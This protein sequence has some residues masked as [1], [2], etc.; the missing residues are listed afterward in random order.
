MV[1]R[2]KTGNWEISEVEPNELSHKLL[3]L[4]IMQRNFLPAKRK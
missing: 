1:H 2:L 4:F 3:S